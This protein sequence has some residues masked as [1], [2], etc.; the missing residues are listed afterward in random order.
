[1]SKGICVSYD[2]AQGI[3]YYLEVAADFIAE[4]GEPE[5]FN[6]LYDLRKNIELLIKTA[7]P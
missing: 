1:M 2:Q 7:N 5:E 4:H 6:D 3:L